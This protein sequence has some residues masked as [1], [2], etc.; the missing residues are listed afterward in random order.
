MKRLHLVHDCAFVYVYVHI[1]LAHMFNFHPSCSYKHS[2][3]MYKFL[4]NYQQAQFPTLYFDYTAARPLAI[5]KITGSILAGGL[6]Y[7]RQYWEFNINTAVQILS[8]I[9]IVITAT[10]V[11]HLCCQTWI[12]HFQ[13]T[14]RHVSDFIFSTN[15]VTANRCHKVTNK[16][17]RLMR[18][19]HVNTLSYSNIL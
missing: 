15:F 16:T 4:F 3:A 9:H 10:K 8:S 13:T 19:L 7:S 12:R 6:Y 2:N 17:R 14:Q 11:I 18:S 1:I 5:E